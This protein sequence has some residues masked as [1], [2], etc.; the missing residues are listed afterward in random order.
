MTSAVLTGD[1]GG[2]KTILCLVDACSSRSPE[3]ARVQRILH[4]E[5]FA[6]LDFPD[7]VPMVQKFLHCAAALLGHAPSLEKACFGI[8]GPVVD[9]A[10]ELTNLGWSLSAGR[11]SRE[12]GIARVR[13]INDF[14]A[15]GYGIAA[16]SAA[17]CVTLQAG[18]TDPQ[19]P[20]ALIGAGTGLGEG[21][22][23]PLPGGGFRMF[24][25]EGSHA[26]FAPRSHR[27]VQLLDYLREQ[28]QITRVSAERVISGR[29]ITAIYQFLRTQAPEQES[30]ALADR[31]HLWEQQIGTAEKTVD[32]A[33]EISGA[34]LAG[35][36]YLCM[37]TM[38]LFIE[39]YGAEAGNLCLKL[40]PDGGLYVAGGIAPKILPLLQAGSFMQAFR[41]KGRMSSRMAKIP[42]HVV[43]NSRVGLMGAALCANGPE[44]SGL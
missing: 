1:I 11:L 10:S 19:A 16:L 9:N 7:L 34:A 20:R 14:T 43:M 37:Q 13:L 38:N 12:L 32:L 39:A 2:T 40:L 25:S 6:S 36:D 26:D 28:H 30:P 17:D 24:P 18:V 27:E 41:D 31:Y 42:V 33:A 35:T 8:A 3:T 4:E 21:F 29:G 22:L 23:A 44:S 15:V 5:I